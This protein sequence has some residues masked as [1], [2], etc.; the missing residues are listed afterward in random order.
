MFQLLDWQ[1]TQISWSGV[2]LVPS[3]GIFSTTIGR[4][5]REYCIALDLRVLTFPMEG[6]ESLVI[7]FGFRHPLICSLTHSWQMGPLSMYRT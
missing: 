6:M 2:C 4:T 3:Q 7:V 5:Q 1:V